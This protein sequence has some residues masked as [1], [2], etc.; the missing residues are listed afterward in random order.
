MNP[1]Q[2]PFLTRPSGFAVAEVVDRVLSDWAYL[3]AQ[4]A[5]MPAPGPAHL[6][7]EFAV[8]LS[9]PSDFLLVMRSTEALGSAVAVASTGD[10]GANGLGPDAFRELVNLVAGHL[11]TE[12]LDGG[13]ALYRSFLPQASVPSDWPACDP[14]G[15][16]LLLVDNH[17]LEIRLWSTQPASGPHA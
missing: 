16:A 5:G 9:G 11:L 4:P 15:Q 13:T 8:R 14:M 6:P 3:S 12:C 17:P 1:S 2:S 7:L 10:P